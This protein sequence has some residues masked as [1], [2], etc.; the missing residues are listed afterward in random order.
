MPAGVRICGCSRESAQPRPAILATLRFAHHRTT[1]V[2]DLRFF[3]HGGQDDACRFGKPGAPKLA[4][5]ALH[6]LAPL[7]VNVPGLP[8]AGFSAD[9]TWPD[10][11]DP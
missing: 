1:A 7:G 10:L 8:M 9:P 6:R 2:V 11:G 3:S 4:N 5:E